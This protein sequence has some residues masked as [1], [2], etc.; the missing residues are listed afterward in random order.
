MSDVTTAVVYGVAL[1]LVY[2]ASSY[3]TFLLAM[4]RPGVQFIVIS[5]GGMLLRMM[6]AFIAIA[7][8]TRV[9]DVLEQQFFMG[10]LAT[11]IIVLPI[12]IGAMHYGVGVHNNEK[13][14]NEVTS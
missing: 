10:F 9:L 5:L 12:E 3:L 2:G 6:L 13:T 11:F 8:L 4:K 14:S 1:G 7:V